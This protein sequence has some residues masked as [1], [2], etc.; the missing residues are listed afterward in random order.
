M[1]LAKTREVIGER[2]SCFGEHWDCDR[3][4]AFRGRE[5][6]GVSMPVNVSNGQIPQLY[7]AYTVDAKEL[8]DGKIT[9]SGFFFTID[10]IKELFDGLF[11]RCWLFLKN[12]AHNG[13]LKMFISCT[14]SSHQIARTP[15][16]QTPPV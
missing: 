8:N 4:S 9:T 6:N 5:T 3:V 12:M 1:G 11:Q 14:E 16:R 15:V 13:A 10:R 7:S 2:I